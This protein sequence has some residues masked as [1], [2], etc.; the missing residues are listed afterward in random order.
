MRGFHLP[1]KA[2]FF[3]FAW[4]PLLSF[5]FTEKVITYFKQG[6]VALKGSLFTPDRAHDSPA[7][8]L[9]HE[10]GF[11]E[12]DRHCFS[13]Y[14]KFFTDRGY[15]FLSINYR[16][17]HQGGEY[18]VALQDCIEALRWLK[19][20]AKEN[21]IDKKRIVVMGASAGAYLSTMIGISRGLPEKIR[22]GHRGFP[23]ED[24]RVAG[25]GS[26]FGLYDWTA[27]PWPGGGFIKPDQKKETSPIQY[28]K[29]ASADFLL[30]GR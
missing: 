8:L 14:G 3:F 2:L 26:V 13:E 30:L 11:S 10:G 1:I 20:H 12:G 15:A 29:S 27:T 17:V 7:L 6:K 16:L 5:G 9:I 24:N 23:G 18:P 28:F 19:A 21:G 4:F 22:R 25:V